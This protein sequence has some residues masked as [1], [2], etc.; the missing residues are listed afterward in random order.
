[1]YKTQYLP[2]SFE[3]GKL[4]ET[5]LRHF[6]Y[7]LN[8]RSKCFALIQDDSKTVK[9]LID[10]NQKVVGSRSQDTCGRETSTSGFDQL[11]KIYW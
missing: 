4:K 5:I 3:R 11:Y 7:N 9:T 10:Q 1:M 2:E 6:P 8:L